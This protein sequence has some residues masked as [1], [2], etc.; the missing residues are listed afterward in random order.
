MQCNWSYCTT[1][2]FGTIRILYLI[3]CD[4]QGVSEVSYA[5]MP[6]VVTCLFVNK[7]YVVKSASHTEG[8]QNVCYLF[9]LPVLVKL[10]CD[11]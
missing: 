6:H 4:S 7:L 10:H 5:Q 8:Q 1:S 11:L 2:V 9:C 3:Q